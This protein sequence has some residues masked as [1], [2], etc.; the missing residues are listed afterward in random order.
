MQIEKESMLP[1]NFKFYI[2]KK[3]FEFVELSCLG[4]DSLLRT[5]GSY[6]VADIMTAIMPVLNELNLDITK[7]EGESEDAQLNKLFTYALQ[8]ETLWGSLAICFLD[9]L[10]IGPDVICASLSKEDFTEENELYIK[11]NITV[12]QEP[13]VLTK[14]L[15]LNELP[16]TLK[17]YSSLLTRVQTLMTKK[18]S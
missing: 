8:N 10:K 11:N 18:N 9:A 17:N 16:Q 15:E 2:G 3:E 4:R 12:R 13:V 7:K 5:I 6:T 14:I 1:K